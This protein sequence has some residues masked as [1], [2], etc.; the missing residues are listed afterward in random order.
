M[1][2]LFSL[3]TG[4]FKKVEAPCKVERDVIHE[5]LNVVREPCS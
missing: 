3:K 5:V 1:L 4:R 2:D